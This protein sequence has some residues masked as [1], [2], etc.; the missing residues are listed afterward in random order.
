MSLHCDLHVAP[1]LLEPNC[2]FT[3]YPNREQV[4]CGDTV[5]F[6]CEFRPKTKW[7]LHWAHLEATVHFGPLEPLIYD[8]T[9]CIS[10]EQMPVNVAP[11][12]IAITVSGK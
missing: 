2:P 12:N 11:M 1:L 7:N 8:E 5:N 9:V 3:I 6:K 10:S 4:D